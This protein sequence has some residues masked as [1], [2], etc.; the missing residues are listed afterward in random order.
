MSSSAVPP[1]PPSP[2]Y[3]LSNAA[4]MLVP[5]LPPPP[6]PNPVGSIDVEIASSSLMEVDSKT[7]DTLLFRLFYPSTPEAVKDKSQVSWLPIPHQASYLAGY[8]R[9]IGLRK[10][11]ANVLTYTPLRSLLTYITIPAYELA[12][13]KEGT[14]PVVIFSH[15]LGGTRHAYSSLCT[16]LASQGAL[17]L[18]VEHRDGSA[19]TTFVREYITGKT[20]ES[21]V[22]VEY[23]ALK[24][25]MDDNV[26]QGRNAQLEKRCRELAMAFEAL[27]KLEDG[28]LATV[29]GIHVGSQLEQTEDASY[30]LLRNFKGQLPDVNVP[31]RVIFTG[32]SFGAATTIQFLKSVYYPPIPE[33]L[34]TVSPQSPLKRQITSSTP[35]VLLDLWCLP[36]LGARTRPLYAL[37]LPGYQSP[38]TAT[39]ILHLHSQQFFDWPAGSRAIWKTLSPQPEATPPAKLPDEPEKK[40]IEW[41]LIETS[42]HMGPSDFTMLTPSF[43]DRD[44]KR[45]CSQYISG[46]TGFLKGLGYGCFEGEVTGREL[47]G[48]EWGDGGAEWD[49][50]E[51]EKAD[52]DGVN[53]EDGAPL[54]KVR[55]TL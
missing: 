23:V 55:S 11:T 46:V 45:L 20:G 24:H 51:R 8:G 16:A 34:F 31:G 32:H 9:F 19:P 37:P 43:L 42:K 54:K 53:Q 38:T 49:Q 41:R 28:S 13:P 18:S 48:G 14:M 44:A 30:E 40:K 17:V 26:A 36:L 12:K 47:R 39:T 33:P 29:K 52:K 15:G 6:G 5:S 27:R 10:L 50:K 25:A 3:P 21:R 2:G 7:P 1:L 4:A 22:Q 35:T